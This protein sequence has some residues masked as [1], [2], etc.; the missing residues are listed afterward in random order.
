MISTFI[1]FLPLLK[2]VASQEEE[3]KW[4]E[5]HSIIL[6]TTKVGEIMWSEN[7]QFVFENAISIFLK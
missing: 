7:N 6:G 1:N 2:G 5:I 4:L 3:H